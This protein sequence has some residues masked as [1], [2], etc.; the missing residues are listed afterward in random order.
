MIPLCAMCPVLPIKRRKMQLTLF[1]ES[2][3]GVSVVYN[4]KAV[5]LQRTPQRETK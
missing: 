5:T 4:K 2:F 1:N 3:V